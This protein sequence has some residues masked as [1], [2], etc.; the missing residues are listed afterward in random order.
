[1]KTQYDFICGNAE[2]H[3]SPYIIKEN[4]EIVPGFESPID[5]KKPSKTSKVMNVVLTTI[6]CAEQSERPWWMWQ[7]MLHQ[8]PLKSTF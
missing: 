5:L 4:G 2:R 8:Q 6:S 7:Q 1:M 3:V